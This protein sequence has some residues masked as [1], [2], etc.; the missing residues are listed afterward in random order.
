MPVNLL[1]PTGYV[2]HQQVQLSTIVR[3]THT[4]FMCFVFIWEQ[5][6]RLAAHHKLIGFYN[7]DEKCLQRG[8]DW[9]F[10]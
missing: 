2:M 9:A 8:T 1:K 10:K 3:S 4:V 5:K 6:Q 7:R